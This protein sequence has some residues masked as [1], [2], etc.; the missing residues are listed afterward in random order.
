MADEQ[1]PHDAGDEPIGDEGLLDILETAIEDERVAQDKYRRGLECC[2]DAE[3][4]R[5]FRQLLAEEQAHE[6][7]LSAR[8]AEVKK[9]IG[10]HGAGRRG[11]GKDAL[12]REVD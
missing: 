5:V 8:Y 2:A 12:D 11:P 3:A 6:R 10:L 1:K 4:C 9:R 7:A